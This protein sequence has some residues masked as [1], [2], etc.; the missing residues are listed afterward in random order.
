M[1][2]G[3]R[4]K[5][6]IDDIWRELNAPRPAARTAAAAAVGIAGDFGIPGVTTKT[7]ML[8]KATPQPTS[9]SSGVRAGLG[10]PEMAAAA[11][12]GA[13]GAALQPIVPEVAGVSGND[14]QSYLA[15]MQVLGSAVGLGPRGWSLPL[16]TGSGAASDCR[17]PSPLA[18]C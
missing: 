7:R 5:R 16:L 12:G 2:P 15:G 4:P 9:H 6:S 3:G 8:P 13:S 18:R 10:A 17:C 14:L 11:A 1:D